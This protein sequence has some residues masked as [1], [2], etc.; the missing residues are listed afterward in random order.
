M[1]E[2]IITMRAALRKNLEDLGSKHQWKHITDQVRL[3]LFRF[4]LACC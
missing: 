2:R 3:P 4:F 1:A